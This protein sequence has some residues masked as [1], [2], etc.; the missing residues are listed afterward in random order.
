MNIGMRSS[1]LFRPSSSIPL[2]LPEAAKALEAAW[3]RRRQELGN[4]QPSNGWLV[5]P[6]VSAKRQPSAR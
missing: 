5:D 3:Q 6:T 1:D 2:A 4:W